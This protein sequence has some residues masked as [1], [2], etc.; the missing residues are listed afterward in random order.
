[1]TKASYYTYTHMLEYTEQLLLDRAAVDIAHDRLRLAP[2]GKAKKARS[3][4]PRYDSKE[5]WRQQ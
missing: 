4:A 5:Y 3:R 2:I 1:M